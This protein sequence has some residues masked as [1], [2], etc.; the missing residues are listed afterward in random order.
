M[1][2]HRRSAAT[3]IIP[4]RQNRISAELLGFTARSSEKVEFRHTSITMVVI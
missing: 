3:H 2:N 4:S 1:D